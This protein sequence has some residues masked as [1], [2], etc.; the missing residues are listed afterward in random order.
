MKG[1][2]LFTARFLALISV[3]ALL[4][5]SPTNPGLSQATPSP[6]IAG[7]GYPIPVNPT[8]SQSLPD[9]NN[10]A[11]SQAY[12]APSEPAVTPAA[13]LATRE[14]TLDDNGK[15]I[16]LGVNEQVLLK[17]GDQYNWTI[18]VGDPAIISRVVNILVVR[19]AQGVYETHR[20]G[21]TTLTAT[22]DPPCRTANP[23]CAAP[24]ILFQIQ[25]IVQ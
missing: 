11:P 6:A 7:T 25:V 22:G 19:G 2:Q 21:Q 23:P 12:P 3:A 20:P 24:S 14:I 10:G 15:N 18:T 5:C 17:L 4:G 13:T 1:L 16:T 8:P 9:S